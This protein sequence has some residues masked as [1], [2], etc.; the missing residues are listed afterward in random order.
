MAKRTERSRFRIGDLLVHPDRKI[1]IRD[2]E[3]IHL[4]T[5]WMQVLVYLAEHHKTTVGTLELMHAVWGSTEFEEGAVHSTISKLRSKVLRDDPRAPRY[6]QT[7]SGQGYRLIAPVAWPDDYLSG[8]SGSSNWRRGNPYVGL[9]A[10]DEAHADVFFGRGDAVARVMTAMRAQF[11]NGQRFVLLVGASGSGKTSLLNAGVI[12][13]LTP[14]GGENGLRALS[15]A[16]CDLGAAADGDALGALAGA[17]A[18]WTLDD[19]PVLPPQPIASLK[20]A[21]VESRE[22]IHAAIDETFRRHPVRLDTEPHAHLLLVLDHSEALVA[23]SDRDAA[24][25]QQTA[26]KQA[27]AR[28]VQALETLCDHPRVLATMIVRG[29]FYPKLMEA[30]PTLI[31]RKGGFGHVDVARP[32]AIEI[33]E[34]ITLPAI[35][36]GLE[37]ERDPDTRA[38]HHLNDTLAEAARGQADVLPLL[39]HTLHELYLRCAADKKLTYAAY[40]EIGGLEGAIAQRAEEVFASLPADAQASLDS[41]LGQLVVIES[42]SDAIRGKPGV[43]HRLSPD[44]KRF[45]QAFI[46]ARLFAADG[47]NTFGVSHEALL[48]QWPRAREWA[49][50]NQRLLQAHDRFDTAKCHWIS[51]GKRKDYLLNAGIPLSEAMQA[52]EAFPEKLD[53]DALEYLTLSKR[54]HARNRSIK[55]AG[56]A[57]LAALTIVFAGIATVAFLK[58]GEAAARRIES[59]ERAGF[60]LVDLYDAADLQGNLEMLERISKKI[61]DDCE[62]SQLENL[63]ARDLVN[64]SRGYRILGRV[65]T[66]QKKPEEARRLLDQADRMARMALELDPSLQEA[67]NEIGQS[68]YGKGL[69]EFESNHFEVA[70]AYWKGYL[71]V[72]R[73][74]LKVAPRNPHWMFE[75]SYAANNLGTIEQRLGR[76][77]SSLRFHELSAHLKKD[78]IVFSTHDTKFQKDYIDTLSWISSAMEL[79]GRL[80]EASTGYETQIAE[81]YKLLAQDRTDDS[82]R[83]RLGSYLQ[84]DSALQIERGEIERAARSSRESLDQIEDIDARTFDTA[85]RL[86]GL[87][88]GHLARSKVLL[89][90]GERKR[91]MREMVEALNALSSIPEEN[92]ED[93]IWKRLNAHTRYTLTQFFGYRGITDER[94]QN[95]HTMER[96]VASSPT[97]EII[98]D[99]ADML[100]APCRTHASQGDNCRHNAAEAINV[101]GKSKSKRHAG[102]NLLWVEANLISGNKSVAARH[103]DYLH[104]INSKNADIHRTLNLRPLYEQDSKSVINFF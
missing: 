10:F 48:R 42:D 60:M 83:F 73:I 99:Y 41:V 53:Q 82:W 104:S 72:S 33:N 14:N 66:E 28:F 50:E 24:P 86:M 78:A 93:V 23:T 5:R 75:V 25:E 16:R 102:W 45:V 35:A 68:L 21:L 39:Q 31:E 26:A 22:S 46:D 9:A 57:I 8:R 69:I 44:A 11:E 15:V 70:W 87:A 95:L 96:L 51:S 13:R 84:L 1:I 61:V 59:Q 12:P 3:E 81:T 80:D 85:K 90:N 103:T 6:I 76:P 63:D 56:T 38:V 71:N 17:V 67:I 37:F 54:M 74:L 43:Q 79:D 88:R 94:T 89:A 62:K 65:R 4:E 92:Q 49:K 29:D 64:C 27:L 98:R 19:R 34:I 40:R 2:G 77:E 58:S 30:V 52:S 47:N 18:G 97:D 7:I 20:D 101:L 36:A 100:I 32:T 55:R 91:A